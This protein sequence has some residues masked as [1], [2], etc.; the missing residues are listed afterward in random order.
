[1]KIRSTLVVVCLLAAAASFSRAQE[2][3][4]KDVIT[5][6]REQ[7][8]KLLEEHQKLLEEM[9]EMKAFKARFEESQKKISTLQTET[10]QS[11]DDVDKQIRAAKQMA[12]DSFPG[13]TKTLLT[14]YGS[15][16]FI[17]QDHGGDRKF[18]ATFNPIFLW[19][20]NDR[21]LFEGELEAELEGSDT[22]LA[23]EMAQISYIVND[24]V[25]FGA[26]KFLNPMDYFVERQH[27]A[28]VNKFPDKPLAV[29]DGLLPETEVGAQI[30][31][32]VPVGPTK[33][34][35]AFYVANANAL[36]ADTNSFAAN[37]L[38][39]LTFD[40]F[41]NVGKN[42]AVG[43]RIGFFP[44]P[45][46][47]VGYGFQY[48]DVAPPHSG[49][50]DSLLQSVDLSYVRESERLKGIVNL[51]VQ[52]VWSHIDRFTYDPGGTLGG[53]FRFNN[54]RDG[55]YVQ[56]AYRPSRIGNSFVK[57]LEPVFRYDML[58]Q[59]RTPTGT[60]ESRYSFGLNYWLGPSSVFKVAYEID[61]QSGPN[62]DRHNATLV[63][64]ATGF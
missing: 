46:L 9:K 62:A 33:L 40:N 14:G 52:W 25:T 10:D 56:L 32:G 22:S 41:D 19:K 45:E 55:G 31:G 28:W 26:G 13:S 39:T 29:Y 23:L 21:L 27:M 35:Y 8:Q 12:K 17:S 48:A 57:N 42:L 54:N 49:S 6:P 5:I 1:M 15:A 50:V 24:Y 60:D 51:K 38:G 2:P 37:D 18:S 59:A 3:A 7:Y 64:F 53:P 11:F 20:L 47:E 61:E 16:G 63:Q 4:N 44:I 43:G 36:N 30:R 34:G 58:S